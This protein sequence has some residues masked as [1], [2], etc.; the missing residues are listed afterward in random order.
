[1]E[2]YQNRGG[3]SGVVS[4]SISADS[5]IVQFRDG[6][7]YLYNAVRPGQITVDHM[8]NLAIAGQGLNSYISR[9]VRKNYYQK[10]R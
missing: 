10:L 5:I 7:Q 3:N 1:M 8:K 6:S 4:F 9:T 2:K